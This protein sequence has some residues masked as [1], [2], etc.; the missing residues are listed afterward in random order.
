M[1]T[2]ARLNT[3]QQEQTDCQLADLFTAFHVDIVAFANRILKDHYQ[4]ED[5]AQEAYIRFQ[6]KI[7]AGYKSELRAKGYLYRIVRNL[8]IDYLRR[9]NYERR[10]FPV[11]SDSIAEIIPENRSTLE[12]AVIAS[13]ELVR[14]LVGLDMLPERTRI[15]FEMHRFGG[16]TMQKIGEHFGISKSMATQ[17]V[18]DGLVMC[19]RCHAS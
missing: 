4:S 14:I 6:A 12:E 15:A 7:N 18:A 5:V 19:R 16:Y 8:S 3:A 1:I 13:E 17:L 11:D 9:K 10:L 2:N